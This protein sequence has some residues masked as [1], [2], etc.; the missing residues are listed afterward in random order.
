M[1][2]LAALS[3]AALMASYTSAQSTP[4]EHTLLFP[5]A[6]FHGTDGTVVTTQCTTLPGDARIGSI[7]VSLEESCILYPYGGAPTNRI[8]NNYCQGDVI[9]EVDD[10]VAQFPDS[11]TWIGALCSPDASADGDDDF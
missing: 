11:E 10:N 3:S 6:N 7:R 5:Q 8:R 2:F 4:Y 9:Q 1:R